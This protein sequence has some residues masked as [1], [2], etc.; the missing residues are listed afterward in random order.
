MWGC[1]EGWWREWNGKW[2]GLRVDEVYSRVLVIWV[3]W[4]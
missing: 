2:K 3:M 1:G 4:Y